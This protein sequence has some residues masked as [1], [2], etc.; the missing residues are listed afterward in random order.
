[1]RD[2]TLCWYV[3]YLIAKG[4]TLVIARL[5]LTWGISVEKIFVRRTGSTCESFSFSSL[6][7]KP[8]LYYYAGESVSTCNA[9]VHEK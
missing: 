9:I 3:S 1:M 6:Y 7:A 5:S 4:V 2:N 8:A